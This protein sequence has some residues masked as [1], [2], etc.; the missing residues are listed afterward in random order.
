MSDTN[1]TS[2]TDPQLPYH[3]PV[4]VY[5]K[6]GI[7]GKRLQAITLQRAVLH[8]ALTAQDSLTRARAI[9]AWT[10]LQE[11]IRIID[12]KL[13]PGSVNESRRGVAEPAAKPKRAKGEVVVLG[14]TP[15]VV[16][17]N[18]VKQ[19]EDGPKE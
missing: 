4:N 6:R 18:G 16:S 8:D 11:Q 9:H 1:C 15:A 17:D 12:G 2:A 7:V 13:K 10:E 14:D 19:G 5:T 3:I